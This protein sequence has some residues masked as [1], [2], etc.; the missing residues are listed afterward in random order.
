MSEPIL[1]PTNPLHDQRGSHIKYFGTIRGVPSEFAPYD[2]HEAFVTVTRAGALR[3]LHFQLTHPQTKI[4][5]VMRGAVNCRVV[6]LEDGSPTF[7]QVYAFDLNS[8]NLDTLYVPGT[9]ALGYYAKEDS[10]ISYLCD[11]DF[12]PNGDSG[13]AYNDPDLNVDW[14]IPLMPEPLFGEIAGPIV[15][16]KDKTLMSFQRFVSEFGGLK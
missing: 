14:G 10:V 4:I 15:S 8:E 5:T 13:I 2:L 7:G 1:L 12:Y 3:G 6:D 9:C 11:E 16:E